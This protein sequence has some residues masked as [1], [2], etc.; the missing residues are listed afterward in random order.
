M[1]Q[2]AAIV[3][4]VRPVVDIAFQDGEGRGGE[5]ARRLVEQGVFRVRRDDVEDEF[6]H[7]GIVAGQ[8]HAVGIAGK[9]AHDLHQRG[10]R[11]E[12]A[13]LV[14]LR[15]KPQLRAFERALH[16]LGRAGDQRV[17]RRTLVH[18]MRAHQRRTAPAAIVQAAVEIAQGTVVP[19]RFRMA[20]EAECLHVS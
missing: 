8:Q 17:P 6:L 1:H 14:E 7:A 13:A 16:A 19:V 12:V 11:S 18:D 15:I 10:G 3:G 9:V 4:Q 2:L 20:Q 5:L